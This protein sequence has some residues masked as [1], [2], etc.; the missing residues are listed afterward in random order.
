[1]N[2]SKTLLSYMGKRDKAGEV[3]CR[4]VWAN[5]ISDHMPQGEWLIQNM[6]ARTA[7]TVEHEFYL[8]QGIETDSNATF[9]WHSTMVAAGQA[10]LVEVVTDILYDYATERLLPRSIYRVVYPTPGIDTVT[11]VVSNLYG[12]A[13]VVG[14]FRFSHNA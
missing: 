14:V 11:V 1:M 13:A 5:I 3:E 6:A 12:M 4:V 7:D 8:T 9:L 2:F 10:T